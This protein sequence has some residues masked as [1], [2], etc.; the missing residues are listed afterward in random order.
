M[1]IYKENALTLRFQ[2]GG[3]FGNEPKIVKSIFTKFSQ[4][5][6]KAGYKRDFN[7]DEIEMIES[8]A[9]AINKPVKEEM[10]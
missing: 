10:E 5:T 7:P 1:D 2:E 3:D 8:I 6:K 9:V 4:I